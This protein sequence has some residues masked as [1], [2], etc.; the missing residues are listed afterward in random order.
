MS[1]DAGLN[2]PIVASSLFSM[3]VRLSS[4]L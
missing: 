1:D 3:S 4:F 2:S